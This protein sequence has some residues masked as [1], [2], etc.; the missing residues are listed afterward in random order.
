[1]MRFIKI[2]FMCFMGFALVAFWP[3]ENTVSEVFL[4]FC[5][6]YFLSALIFLVIFCL[7]R[8]WKMAV[9]ASLIMLYAGLFLIP[10]LRT[11][12][13][14][15][16]DR[17]EDITILQFNVSYDHEDVR[18]VVSWITEKAPDI[19]VIQEATPDICE[20]L[21][22][23]S[24]SY[25]HSLSN[26]KMGAYGMV[27]YSKLP[28]QHYERSF[29]GNFTNEYTTVAFQ[30]PEKQIPFILIE[31]HAFWPFGGRGLDERRYE[32]SSIS[33]IIARFPDTRKLLIGDLNTTPYSPYFKDLEKVSGLRNA[34]RGSN[35]YGT[36]PNFL[37]PPL[38]IP[39]DHLLVSD[40]IEVLERQVC[41]DWGSDH[42]P[43]ISKIRIYTQ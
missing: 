11:A 13:V 1:M 2:I 6:Q 43:V 25:P 36:W 16:A 19:V 35:F 32:L 17:F 37:P 10:F 33:N 38:R 8:Q 27:L 7:S 30:T 28:L 34:M 4:N 31:L 22:D 3:I 14:L 15:K 20:H 9:M 29:I 23:L 12:H 21:K 39:I 24:V 41:P 5:L 18:K 40:K 42:L 26:P